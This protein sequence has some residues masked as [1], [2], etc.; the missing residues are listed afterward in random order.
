MNNNKKETKNYFIKLILFR[1][2]IKDFEIKLN[3][4]SLPKYLLYFRKNKKSFGRKK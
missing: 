2:K 3:F 4:E 1:N